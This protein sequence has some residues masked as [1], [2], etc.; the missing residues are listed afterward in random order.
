MVQVSKLDSFVDD[1]KILLSFPIEEAVDAKHHFETN[2][3]KVATWCCENELL[4]NPE[5]TKFL[6]VETRQLLKTLPIDMS[7]T[8]LKKNLLPAPYAKDLGVAFG[9][10]LTF[11]NHVG[12]VVSSCMAK[13]CQINRVKHCF[14]CDTLIKIIT[15]LV[16]SKLYYCSSIWSNTSIG[17]IKKLQ[18]DQNVACR[19]ITNTRKFDHITPALFKIGWLSVKEHLE[20]RDIIMCISV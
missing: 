9:R 19:I 13:L 3:S 11:D 16:L 2:L 4:I 18:A 15:T 6:L 12:D 17:N 7:L 1:S 14:D 5:K 20:Y 8:F 10:Y